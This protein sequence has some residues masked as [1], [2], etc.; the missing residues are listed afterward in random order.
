MLTA[1]RLR[2][3][4][5]YNP[6]TGVFTWKVKYARAPLGAKA[7]AKDAYGYVV[8]RV[9]KVLYKA[10][11]LAWLYTYGEWPKQSVDHINRVRDD[12]RIVNLR[13]VGQSINTLNGPLRKSNQ[14]GV[15]GVQWDEARQRWVAR[16]KICYRQ[17]Y[18]GRYETKEEAIAARKAAETN[19]LEWTKGQQ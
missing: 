13:D 12:N 1:H 14:S 3:L 9:D 8:I 19:L 16:I 4:L 10:H 11:R 6:D 18:L 7:G 5:A 17:I 2:E 15:T